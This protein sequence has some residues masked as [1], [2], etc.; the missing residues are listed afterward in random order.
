[1]GRG[2]AAIQVK[3]ADRSTDCPM[4]AS[5]IA[6]DLTD[7]L[8]DGGGAMFCLYNHCARLAG[9]ERHVTQAHG[10]LAH[11]GVIGESTVDKSP[12]EYP[13]SADLSCAA[14]RIPP[15]S[16]DNGNSR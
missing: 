13:A 5:W 1:M 12:D 11:K 9:F 7:V 6:S 4:P 14:D 16:A 3:L 2:H 15:V 10:I 8:S